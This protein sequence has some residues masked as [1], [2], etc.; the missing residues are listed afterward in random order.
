ME[1]QVPGGY[2]TTIRTTQHGSWT[3]QIGSEV[4]PLGATFW[5]CPDLKLLSWNVRIAV[6]D[7]LATFPSNSIG[8][9]YSP[10]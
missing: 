6:P 9:I 2:K 8:P 4:E 1:A 5:S 10:F 7:P 3:Y